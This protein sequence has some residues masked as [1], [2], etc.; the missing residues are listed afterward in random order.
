MKHGKK[1]VE[2]LKLIE[3]SKLY[4]PDEA[5]KL[6]RERLLLLQARLKARKERRKEEKRKKKGG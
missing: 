5:V 3:S 6:A 1:Y 2:S 4:D